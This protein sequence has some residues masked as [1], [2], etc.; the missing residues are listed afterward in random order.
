MSGA[1]AQA[2][3]GAGRARRRW[4]DDIIPESSAKA[5]EDDP[6]PGSLLR[7]S[8]TYSKVHDGFKMQISAYG[9]PWEK[10]RD[11]LRK[12]V[13]NCEI[14]EKLAPESDLFSVPVPRK[15]K[16]SELDDIYRM[17]DVSRKEEQR[18]KDRPEKLPQPAPLPSYS[19]SE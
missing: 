4:T 15:L 8:T 14:P 7:A 19:D 11:Y 18:I 16:Q 9:L 17:R 1:G 12:H 13:E 5:Q 6:T 2:R 3:F 10:L